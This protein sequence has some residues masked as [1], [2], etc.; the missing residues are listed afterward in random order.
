MLRKEHVSTNSMIRMRKGSRITEDSKSDL[1]MLVSGLGA[2][3][4]LKSIV[5]YPQLL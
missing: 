3:Q 1:S 2:D 4:L 5:G